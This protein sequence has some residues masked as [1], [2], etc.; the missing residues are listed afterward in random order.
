M[1][2]TGGENLWFETEET[3]PLSE[4][5]EAEKTDKE[6][7]DDTIADIG[8]EKLAESKELA[9]N[10]SATLDNKIEPYQGQTG[11]NE[12]SDSSVSSSD[13][14]ESSSDSTQE[15][16]KLSG[17]LNPAPIASFASK[18]MGTAAEVATG[19]REMMASFFKYSATPVPGR[20]FEEPILENLVKNAAP[21]ISQKI[22]EAI[23]NHTISKPDTQEE[24]SKDIEELI[25][26][27][28]QT[29]D[30]QTANVVKKISK[31]VFENQFDDI[32]S[33]QVNQLTN[34]I[35]KA[36]AIGKFEDPETQ[37]NAKDLTETLSKKM[38]SQPDVDGMNYIDYEELF[39]DPDVQKMVAGAIG[40]A[41]AAALAYAILQAGK[42]L[43][44]A[45]AVSQM[46]IRFVAGLIIKSRVLNKFKY[47][48]PEEIIKL[49]ELKRL[50]FEQDAEKIFTPSQKQNADIETIKRSISDLNNREKR[51]IS[52]LNNREIKTQGDYRQFLQDAEK[53]YLHRPPKEAEET[54]KIIRNEL[55]NIEEAPF[56]QTPIQKA[57]SKLIEEKA[58]KPVT[59]EQQKLVEGVIKK[60]PELKD[61]EEIKNLGDLR[62]FLQNAEGFVT[63]SKEYPTAET[64]ET[65]K[66]I[67]NELLNIE[68]AAL[69]R[70]NIQKT[71]HELFQG[72]LVKVVKWIE[73]P[74]KLNPDKLEKA[75]AISYMEEATVKFLPNNQVKIIQNFN[76]GTYIDATLPTETIRVEKAVQGL[77]SH[78]LFQLTLLAK[79]KNIEIQDGKIVITDSIKGGQSKELTINEVE[80]ILNNELR[81]PMRKELMELQEEILSDKAIDEILKP[82]YQQCE[83][84][85]DELAKKEYINK[86]DELKQSMIN[87]N[88]MNRE[89]ITEQIN[90]LQDVRTF[91]EYQSMLL[92]IGRQMIF[93]TITTVTT[94]QLGTI[95]PVLEGEKPIEYLYQAIASA[96]VSAPIALVDRIIPYKPSTLTV[97]KK[98]YTDISDQEAS[99]LA[100]DLNKALVEETFKHVAYSS[101]VKGVTTGAKSGLKYGIGKDGSEDIIKTATQSGSFEVKEFLEKKLKLKITAITQE[102]M[103]AI[104]E[105][106]SEQFRNKFI[107]LK[108]EEYKQKITGYLNKVDENVKI[109][110]Q[111]LLEAIHAEKVA[112]DLD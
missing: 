33:L 56:Q 9:E 45:P 83:A 104:I 41:E 95:Y 77:L 94:Y 27:P 50:K 15:E 28:P 58:G 54:L 73:K 76:L 34:E 46:G 6:K 21:Q 90:K 80:K 11:P 109:A 101:I 74:S 23:E 35:E 26:P 17:G 60:V 72:N 37:K 62:R 22:S 48:K 106:A 67:Q 85:S 75:K 103:D 24:I 69:Q 14:S 82:Y 63:K 53:V 88:K 57:A 61:Y 78:M 42:V 100:T 84:W 13:S 39:T 110:E 4:E 12:S 99:E 8:E 68:G 98:I 105:D 55:F 92:E 111:K 47:V 36:L 59:P 19:A 66:I 18:L 10:I 32:E 44:K 49:P 65:L 89:H 97:L 70:P 31:D 108:K 25:F 64:R 1:N 93:A 3:K 71:T 2:V 102:L 5:P 81:A 16:S 43:V 86:L 30:S 112:E 51:L 79:N 52:D 20:D 7:R 38:H 40:V 107:N 87:Y 96:G 91:T 29:P